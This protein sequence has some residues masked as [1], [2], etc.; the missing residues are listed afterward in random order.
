M[1]EKNIL[2]TSL[3]KAVSKN[4]QFLTQI[5][6]DIT[7]EGQNQKD[8]KKVMFCLADDQLIL[9]DLN[10]EKIETIEYENMKSVILHKHPNQKNKI[11]SKIS[12]FLYE[13]SQT[14]E[15]NEIKLISDERN[16]LTKNLLCFY[17]VFYLYSKNEVKDLFLDIKIHIPKNY[18]D[19]TNKKDINK[20]APNSGFYNFHILNEYSFFL[21]YKVTNLSDEKNFLIR[22]GNTNKEFKISV[23]VSPIQ[24][25]NLFETQ[26]DLREISTY[27]YDEAYNYV[28]SNTKQNTERFKIIKNSIYYKKYNFNE[29]ESVWEGWTI[30]YRKNNIQKNNNNF[31]NQ[32]FK[33]QV[34]NYAFVYLRRKF[35][36]PYFDTFRQC[37]LILEEDSKEADFDFS[38]EAIDVLEL[39]AN[40]LATSEKVS[41]TFRMVLEAKMNSLL[42]VDEE[43]FT[44]YLNNL[45]IFEVEIIWI[46]FAFIYSILKFFFKKPKNDKYENFV[47]WEHLLKNSWSRI[48]SSFN[49]DN[50]KNKID[51]L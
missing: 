21:N 9:L 38:K 20:K 14:L 27:A 7:K 13:K 36:S 2:F 6:I 4:I 19:D 26:K 11:N 37:V 48:K 39:A 10:M 35:L 43:I 50:T 44:Y 34:K 25:F 16:Y 28:L 30:R 22:V 18:E 33:I 23:E 45:K 46:G 29:D 3:G 42:I 40:S 32:N 49:E 31:D 41:E 24:K 51:D 8:Q 5:I 15:L 1:N 17:S 47:E 12:I